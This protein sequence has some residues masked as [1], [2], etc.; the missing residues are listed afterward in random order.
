[1]AAPATTLMV[2]ALKPLTSE[3]V[4]G[5]G[6][7]TLDGGADTEVIDGGAGT[8]TATNGKNVINVP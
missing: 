7:D 8:D 1:M 3:T 6:N 4:G 5:N 2:A